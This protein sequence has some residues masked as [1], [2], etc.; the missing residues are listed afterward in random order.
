VKIYVVEGWK[1][2]GDSYL[3]YAGTD[4]N[5]LSKKPTDFNKN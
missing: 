2:F 1:G 4:S 3:E 5:V